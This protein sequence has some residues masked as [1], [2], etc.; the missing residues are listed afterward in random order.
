MVF[1]G[2]VFNLFILT[3]S[4]VLLSSNIYLH[5]W[6]PY[7]NVSI[8]CLAISSFFLGVLCGKK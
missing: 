6:S 5:I 8:A 1:V 3:V 7:M 4:I 2:I